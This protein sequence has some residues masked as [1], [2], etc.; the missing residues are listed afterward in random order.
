MGRLRRR[1][2]GLVAQVVDNRLRGLLESIGSNGKLSVSE[3]EKQQAQTALY[4]THVQRAAQQM[5][6]EA[7]Q[8]QRAREDQEF[9]RA[10]QK[11]LQISRERGIVRQD[12]QIE[13]GRRE[14]AD[15]D[16]A[17]SGDPFEVALADPNLGP[18]VKAQLSRDRGIYG[19]M[20]GTQFAK[21]FA[22]ESLTSAKQLQTQHQGEQLRASIEDNLALGAYGEDESGQETAGKLLQ[23]LDA[24]ATPEEVAREDMKLR[25]SMAK[26]ADK[27]LEQQQALAYAETVLGS[28]QPGTPGA[29]KARRA[30]VAAKHG[31]IPSSKLYE[32][33]EVAQRPETNTGPKQISRVEMK[34]LAH[35]MAAEEAR[36]IG[37][38]DAKLFRDLVEQNMAELMQA[39]MDEQ[40][41]AEAG[42]M[43]QN[44]GQASTQ[45]GPAA[46]SPSGFPQS[47]TPGGQP[48]PPS[49]P[50]DQATAIQA[51]K[52]AVRLGASDDELRAILEAAGLDPDAPAGS[53]PKKTRK[54]PL[55]EGIEP[56]RP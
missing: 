55:R 9:E 24:G 29:E 44:S 23:L 32:E 35:S 3:W 26:G 49:K 43:Q 1:R 52:E 41:G 5:T 17:G 48:A 4:R 14:L 31:I 18:Q 7:E 30:F 33:L 25:L 28:I 21:R 6:H 15:M 46:G 11:A 39:Q 42:R 47:K 36:A 13:K 50:V 40:G 10:Q 54:L 16:A 56:G 8:A 22:T 38:T 19:K 45:Q 37:I 2:R 20:H 51:A 53:L 34:K 27:Q 12:Q